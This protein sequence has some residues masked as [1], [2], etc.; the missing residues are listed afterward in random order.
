[1]DPHQRERPTT[2]LQVRKRK[3]IWTCRWVNCTKRAQTGCNLYCK[4]HYNEIQCSQRNNNEK[5]G[6]ANLASLS[7][8]VNNEGTFADIKDNV[9]NEQ[10]ICN[11]DPR[12]SLQHNVNLISRIGAENNTSV[13]HVLEAS[14]ERHQCDGDVE[15]VYDTELAPKQCA[16][17]RI[18]NVQPSNSSLSQ[19][20]PVRPQELPA[21]DNFDN[22]QMNQVSVTSMAYVATLKKRIKV[23][24][25]QMKISNQNLQRRIKNLEQTILDVTKTLISSLPTLSVDQRS[26]IDPLIGFS[27]W[28]LST[29]WGQA[30]NRTA[31]THEDMLT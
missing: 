21:V 18:V 8:H 6:A 20:M 22:V 25:T 2:V 19:S 3:K 27:T 13:L 5:Q 29:G 9:Y 11:N 26:Q 15:F 1:M 7:N 14:V 17:V 28:S 23:I 10:A 12:V 30:K 24:K 4:A 31:R 16:A